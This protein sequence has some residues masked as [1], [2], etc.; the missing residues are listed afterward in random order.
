M[1]RVSS[2]ACETTLTERF[3]V[4]DCQCPTYEENEGPC[5]TYVVGASSAELC[6]YCDHTEEC[7]PQAEAKLTDYT[8][9]SL[10]DGKI[11][12]HGTW[13]PLV[14]TLTPAVVEVMESEEGKKL[15]KQAIDGCVPLLTRLNEIDRT[16]SL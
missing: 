4:E 15:V 1:K 3:A 12:N 7:H 14:V 8:A 9:Y 5:A 16:K 13:C 6:V 2:P 11:M 10:D